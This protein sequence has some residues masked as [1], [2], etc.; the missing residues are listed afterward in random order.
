MFYRKSIKWLTKMD[1]I[2]KTLII[3][4]RET[5]KMTYEYRVPKNVSMTILL[6]VVISKHTKI[7]KIESIYEPNYYDGDGFY[8]EFTY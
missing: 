5:G 6:F 3:Q 8:K 1:Y 2:R 7:F 4:D